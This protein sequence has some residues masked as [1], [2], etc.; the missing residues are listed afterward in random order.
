MIAQRIGLF[1]AGSEPQVRTRID[2]L[3]EFAPVD[4]SLEDLV[5]WFVRLVGWVRP[6]AGER[7]WARVRFLRQRLEGSPEARARVASALGALVAQVDV[8]TFLTYGG[9]PRDFHLLGVASRWLTSRVLPA[10]CR[11][12]DVEQ[13]VQLALRESDLRWLRASE[14]LPLLIELLPAAGIAVF[15][16]AASEAVRDLVHQV[17]AQA[18]AP[19]IRKLDTDVRSPFRGL[20]ETAIAFLAS[21]ADPALA[22]ALRGRLVQC[23]RA[24][25]TFRDSLASQGADLNTTFQLIRIERQ[26]ERLALLVG[27]LHEGPASAP[28]IALR[29][30]R[31]ALVNARAVRLIRRSSELV[32]RNLVDTTAEVG[33]HYLEEEKSSFHAAMR[34]G[35]GG[36][37]IMVAAT[38][39]KIALVGLRLPAFYAGFV[40]SINYAAAFCA[41]YLLHYTIAT[42]LPAH[43]AA[44]LAK[45]V[46]GTAPRRERVAK[47]VGVAKALVRLQLGGLFGNLIVAGPLAFGIAR[48]LRHVV[49]RTMVDEATA[50]HLLDANS[51]LGPSA[52]YAVLT[53]IFLWVSS[54]VGAAV[55]NWARVNRVSDALATGLRVMKSV[56][57]RRAGPMA[58]A[59]A[60]RVG[61]FTGNAF[62]GFLLG[63]VPAAFAIA[64]LPVE[65]RHVTVSASSVAIGAESV[66]TATSSVALAVAG[67]LIIGLVNVVVSFALALYLALR[68]T[69]ESGTGRLLVRVG[70]R[71]LLRRGPWASSS[72]R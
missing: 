8:G 50:T 36:G 6:G 70:L 9:I 24:R 48:F 23:E 53:G 1:V 17:A 62:L 25:Q 5:F 43:T 45:S 27:G 2:E 67:V 68:A 33:G 22:A 35:M 26:I 52:A 32:V 61:G 51:A 30:T 20:Y 4:G 71:R 66:G 63:G 3:Y 7:A 11:T 16:A 54:L 29:L 21:P 31:S 65:I 58:T 40:L 13:I 19:S 72:G 60:S 64:R 12:D 39:A 57:A 37:L 28:A 15:E 18:H 42:K 56:G 10:A 49:H 69:D 41:A 34:A 47:F 59:I 14:L 38:I 44:A 55:D 46:S